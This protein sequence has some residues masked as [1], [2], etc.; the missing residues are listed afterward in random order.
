MRNMGI[1]R[2]RLDVIGV[3]LL[4]ETPVVTL[5]LLLA[6]P[7]DVP[8]ALPPQLPDAALKGTSCCSH[9]ARYI[10]PSL[11][12]SLR[13]SRAFTLLLR[14]VFV[15]FEISFGVIKA[16]RRVYRAFSYFMPH[17]LKEPLF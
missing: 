13:H 2:L 11:L 10:K 15:H 5:F 3:S 12:H 17:F 4:N 8:V 9:T 6:E 14:G 7:V 1:I 16:A